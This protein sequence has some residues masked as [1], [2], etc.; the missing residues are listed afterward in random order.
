MIPRRRWLRLWGWRRSRSS[1]STSTRPIACACSAGGLGH[2]RV[3]HAV[4]FASAAAVGRDPG[5]RA[6]WAWLPAGPGHPGPRTEMIPP[7][8]Q[9]SPG[10]SPLRRWAGSQG[11][12]SVHTRRGGTGPGTLARHMRRGSP[13]PREAPEWH[14]RWAAKEN[15]AGE[16]LRRAGPRRRLRRA[17]G[18]TFIVFGEFPPPGEPSFGEHKLR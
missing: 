14:P 16:R 4:R 2:T 7:G 12:S 9:D 17:F 13:R 6:K 3:R 15:P 11:Q 8:P 10:F 1:F 5:G 18:G